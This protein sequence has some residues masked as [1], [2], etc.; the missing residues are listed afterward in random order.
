MALLQ[1]KRVMETPNY[2]YGVCLWQLPDKSYIMD[3]EQN[4][5]SVYGR[6]NDPVLESRMIRAA[7]S[8]GVEVG[9]PVWL[10]GFRKITTS[11]WEDQMAELQ[12]GGI[13]DPVDVYRQDKYG[14]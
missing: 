5:L 12:D 1:P 7:K 6:I 11:E 3:M 10:P 4:Y 2:A 8:L 14:V 9:Q 13:P